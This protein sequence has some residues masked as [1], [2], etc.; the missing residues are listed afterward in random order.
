MGSNF[1]D[2]KH[3]I[4]AIEPNGATRTLIS[5]LLREKGFGEV[6]AVPSIRE[7]LAVLETE[8]VSWILSSVF[9]DQDANIFQ[10]LSLVN[11]V[12]HLQEVRVSAFVEASE[13][14]LMPAA[15]ELGLL[16]YHMKPFTKDKLKAEFDNLLGDFESMG[17]R[18]LNLSASYLRKCLSDGGNFPELLLFERQMM[19]G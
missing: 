6:Q 1:R 9:A 3:K 14:E 12:P 8:S 11:R 16:S 5:E 18:S 7:A 13:L 4:I 17:W 2:R 10:L 19:Q 15:F